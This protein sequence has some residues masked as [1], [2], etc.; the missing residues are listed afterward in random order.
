MPPWRDASSLS[1]ASAVVGVMG[2]PVAHSLSPLLHNTAFEQLG[3]HWVSVRFEVDVDAA[4]AAL[5]GVRALGL[6]G[7]SVTMPLKQVVAELVDDVLDPA[8]RLGAVNCVVRRGSRLVG[9]N[10]DGEG[11]LT[12]LARGARF[13][14]RGRPCMVIGA[15]GAAR[16]VALALAR[17]GASE[18][19][20]VN[21]SPGHAE[22]SAALAGERGRVGS[23]EDAPAMALVV[24]ATPA[25]MAHAKDAPARPPVD[26]A[27]LH[28]GQVAVDLVYEPVVTPWLAEARA[29]GATGLGGLGMLVH[30]AAAQLVLWTG[31][32]PPVGVMWRAA[33]EALR[34][35]SGARAPRS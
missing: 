29:Q 9:A 19:V 28:E 8:D 25:G 30:Q 34:G 11:F 12:S 1:A 14:P 23:P 10:T 4:G 26:A 5:G 31:R 20:V 33:Q 27:L 2:M 32:E 17:A 7:V 16:A 6:A 13:E 22:A 3:L 35:A 24:N 21:R 18:V 15:G